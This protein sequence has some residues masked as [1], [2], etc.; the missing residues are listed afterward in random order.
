MSI[1][2]REP[3][4]M[5]SVGTSR[6]MF[7]LLSKF[8][9]STCP[10]QSSFLETQV[11]WFLGGRPAL[12]TSG[13]Q[14]CRGGDPAPLPSHPRILK[15]SLSI[16]LHNYTQH[17][18]RICG[19]GAARVVWRQEDSGDIAENHGLRRLPEAQSERTRVI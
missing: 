1:Q 8:Y 9:S 17:G 19:D 13:R 15:P 12:N 18:F 6:S 16:A 7:T 11:L 14:E 5:H 10:F 3:L 4:N 2:I